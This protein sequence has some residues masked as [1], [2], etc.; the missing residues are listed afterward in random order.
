MPA[1]KNRN[2]NPLLNNLLFE[3]IPNRTGKINQ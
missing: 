3:A 1:M 2:T